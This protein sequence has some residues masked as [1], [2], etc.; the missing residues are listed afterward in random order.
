DALSMYMSAIPW[1]IIRNRIGI[2]DD[3]LDTLYTIPTSKDFGH[4]FG[5]MAHAIVSITTAGYFG[6]SEVETLSKVIETVYIVRCSVLIAVTTMLFLS[7]LVS[8]IDIIRN[9]I[10]RLPQLQASFL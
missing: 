7:V 2:V 4:F 8:V 3:T 1:Y 6:T 9:R 10:K 5:N